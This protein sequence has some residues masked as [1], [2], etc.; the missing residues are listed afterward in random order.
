MWFS[1]AWTVHGVAGRSH[2]L[3]C[4][5][6]LLK[7][8]GVKLHFA[9]LGFL[10]RLPFKLLA[11]DRYF[12]QDRLHFDLPSNVKEFVTRRSFRS[13]ADSALSLGFCDLLSI[14]LQSNAGSHADF[15][16]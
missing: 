6:S 12:A 14:Y 2:T 13:D 11:D 9:K 10:F 4:L 7:S 3:S 5:V 15:R 16:F 8:R 1:F